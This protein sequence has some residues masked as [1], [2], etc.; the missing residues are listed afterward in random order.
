MPFS[1]RQHQTTNEPGYYFGAQYDWDRVAVRLGY[2]KF[3]F[4]GDIDVTETML[5]FFYKL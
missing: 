4:D 1:I 5:T 2:E 3:D